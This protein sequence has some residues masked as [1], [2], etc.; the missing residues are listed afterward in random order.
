MEER[1]RIL[2]RHRT[3]YH[4]CVNGSILTFSLTELRAALHAVFSPFGKVLDI[5]TANTYRLRGQAW[6]VYDTSMDA[7]NAMQ[8][9]QSFPFYD[10]PMVRSKPYFMTLT[11]AFRRKLW[12]RTPHQTQSADAEASISNAMEQFD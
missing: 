3:E 9:L 10:K 7:N 8:S 2:V 1:Q 12:L 11:Y 5:V 6:I 4:E